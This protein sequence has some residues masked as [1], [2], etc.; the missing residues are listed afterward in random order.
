[1]GCAPRYA[2]SFSRAWSL[3]VL[4]RSWPAPPHARD[5][6]LD[7]LDSRDLM[8]TVKDAA[9]LLSVKISAGVSLLALGAL[10]WRFRVLRKPQS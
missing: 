2:R 6:G 4:E 1:M 7:I 8:P 3:P 10:W 5:L 9:Y